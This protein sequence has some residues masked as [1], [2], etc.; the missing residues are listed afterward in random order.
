M[1]R[2]ATPV[3]AAAICGIWNPVIRDTTATFT[4]IEKTPAGITALLADKAAIAH[5]FWVSTAGDEITGFATLA[6]FG[7]A[8]AI[9]IRSNIR[10][11]WPPL[12]AV[13]GR[14]GR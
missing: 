12:H 2:P 6:R 14:A 1:I 7:A 13:W 10:S 4:A 3:D 5:P 9:A 8:T 11:I